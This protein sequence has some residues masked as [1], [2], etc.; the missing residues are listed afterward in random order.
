MMQLRKYEVEYQ[1]IGRYLA[2][3]NVKK[4]NLPDGRV[5]IVFEINEG[6]LLT[7]KNINFIGNKVFSDNELKTKISTKEDAWYKIFGSNKF[8]PERL[9]YDK[10]KLKEFYNERGYIDFKVEIARGDLLPD[11]FWF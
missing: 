11:L 4:I 2:E 7:V 10:E 9:D 3:V 1:K 6:S 5:N 8:I